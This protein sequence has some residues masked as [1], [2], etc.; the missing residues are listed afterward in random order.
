MNLVHVLVR[1][2]KE[3]GSRKNKK[4]CNQLELKRTEY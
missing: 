1:K 2:R 4:K 3:R